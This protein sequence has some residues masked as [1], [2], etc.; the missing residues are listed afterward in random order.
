M[1]RSQ[2]PTLSQLLVKLCQN[3]SSQNTQKTWVLCKGSRGFIRLTASEKPSYLVMSAAA[4]RAL[5]RQLEQ[6]EVEL[7]YSLGLK[8]KTAADLF[9]AAFSVASELERHTLMLMIEQLMERLYLAEEEKAEMILKSAY[10]PDLNDQAFTTAMV[11]VSRERS[12]SARQKI[13]WAFVR[14]SFL[15][16]LKGFPHKDPLGPLNTTEKLLQ[17]LSDYEL[18]DYSALTGYASAAVFSTWASAL[19]CHPEGPAIVEV[20]G[21]AL[22]P[23]LLKLNVGSLLINPRGQIGGEFYRNELI[24]MHEAMTQWE[25]R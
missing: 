10:I 24:S 20:N 23:L 11:H 13:Y 9:E 21:R 19:H 6:S 22:L 14:S 3:R 25:Q 5:K 16:S 8:R 1:I 7:L 18:E 4:G 15:L 2:S 17:N 12:H